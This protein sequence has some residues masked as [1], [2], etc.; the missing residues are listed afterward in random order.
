MARIMDMT[1]SVR[2]LATA[3]LVPIVAGCANTQFEIIGK[4]EYR[5][6]RNSDACAAGSPESVLNYLRQEAVRFCAAR[7]ESPI[8]ARSTTEYGI[9]ALRCASA[10]LVFRCVAPKPSN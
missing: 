1:R 4:D 3:L 7:K 9:P 6:T 2:L 8:E 5:L 10:E